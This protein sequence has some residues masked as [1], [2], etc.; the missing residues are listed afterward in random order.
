MRYEDEPGPRRGAPGPR[1]PPPP[2]A[3]VASTAPP[4]SGRRGAASARRWPRRLL[5]GAN[6]FVALCLIVTAGAYAYIRWQFGRVEKIPFACDVLRNCGDDDPGLPMNV[7]LV[8]SDSRTDISDEE[9]EQFGSSR[10]VGGQRSDTIIVVHVDPAAERAAMLS[11]PRDLLVPIAGS[12]DPDPKQINRAFE[13]GPEVLIATI[14]QSLGIEIDHYAQVDFNGFRGVVDALG[15]VDFYFPAPARDRQTGLNVTMAGCTELDGEAALAYV[16]SREYQ[17][18]EDGKWRADP[19]ADIGRIERQQDFIREVLRTASRQG[20]N[21]L[22]LNSLI[23]TAVKNVTLDSAFSTKDIRRLAGRFRSLEPDAVEIL[24]LPTVP[25]GARLRLKQ[26]DAAAVIDR[27]SGRSSATGG[28]RP[29]V[30]PGSVRVLVLNGTGING[31]AASAAAALREANFGVAGTGNADAVGRAATVVQYAPGQKEKAEL[32]RAYVD[33]GADLRE[34]PSLR[35]GDLVLTT[36]T[37]F[38]G[39]LP[40]AAGAPAAAPTTAAPAP[41]GPAAP[42]PAEPPVPSC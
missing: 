8:G 18:L 1:R 20:R 39:I 25:A 6:I 17:S 23:S 21:P 9:I 37:R 26:P 40:P 19:T 28:E 16:R 32:L 30:V 27:F 4:L 10:Q 2:R 24:S 38:R 7:L 41:P 33:G 36:G 42:E 3:A 11:I 22:T 34:E 13:E 29:E 12:G 31:Q 15:G 5:I 14:R 35:G